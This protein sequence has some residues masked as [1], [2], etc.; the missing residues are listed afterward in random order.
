MWIFFAALST[1]HSPV[2]ITISNNKNRIH[3][4]GVR[5]LKSFLDSDQKYIRKTKSLIQ[6]FHSNQNFIP[7]A[8]RKWEILKYEIRK[9]TI[10]YS[11]TICKRMERK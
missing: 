2:T 6:T 4:H 9:F 11:K 8:Q 10:E 5:K 3:G 7:N 1:D